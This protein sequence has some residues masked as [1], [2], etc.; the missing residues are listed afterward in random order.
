M[1]FYLWM[2]HYGIPLATTAYRLKELDNPV[3]KIPTTAL[4]V[5]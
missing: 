4:T 3:P 5:Y 2:S 1:T